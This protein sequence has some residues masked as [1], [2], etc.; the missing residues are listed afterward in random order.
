[1]SK[2]KGNSLGKRFFA[3]V[4]GLCKQYN[5]AVFYNYN[6]GKASA[7]VNAKSGH[8]ISPHQTLIKGMINGQ[9]KWAIVCSAV[10]QHDGDRY[11][12]HEEFVL[13]T[14][15]KQA[16]LADFL[17][18]RHAALLKAQNQN[19]LLNACWLASPMGNTYSEEHLH[20]LY[21]ELGAFINEQED[22]A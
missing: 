17:S 8:I 16:D 21:T 12:K 18:E 10:C 1:M 22:V 5:I 11:I 19:H 4:S 6:R 3:H 9:Y 20:W 2:R 7:L 14:P 15:C 13:H